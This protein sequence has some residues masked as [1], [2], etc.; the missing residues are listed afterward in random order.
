MDQSLLAAGSL[1]SSDEHKVNFSDD[2]AVA[3][4]AANRSAILANTHE[5]KKRVI[6]PIR[7]EP[8][9]F[10]ANERTFLKWLRLSIVLCMI[11]VALLQTTV[12]DMAGAVFII[13]GLLIT[14]R[15]LYVFCYRS[16]QIRTL[17]DGSFYDQYTPIT[18]VILFIVGILILS[19]GKNN[20][21]FFV[22]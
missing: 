6:I 1:N 8:R 21:S 11:G 22:V 9:T 3:A 4:N 17:G 14:V 18:V 10:M 15:A 12:S 20:N 16:Y 5:D 13:G 19:Y 2:A 7:G